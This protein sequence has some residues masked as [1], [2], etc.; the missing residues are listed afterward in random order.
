M[1][2]SEIGCEDGR[3]MELAHDRFHWWSF[4]LAVFNLRVLLLEYFLLLI[5]IDY[6]LFKVFVLFI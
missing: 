3:W 2:L 6:K 4:E 1:D 5:Y